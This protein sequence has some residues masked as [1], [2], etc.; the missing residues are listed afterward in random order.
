MPAKSSVMPCRPRMG[1][2]ARSD[3][4]F[5][6]GAPRS[7]GAWSAPARSTAESGSAR[8]GPRWRRRRLAGPPSPLPDRRS[9]P[10]CGAVP[11]RAVTQARA[12][13]LDGRVGDKVYAPSRPGSPA[14]A[15]T[16][17][18]KPS[19]SGQGS[20]PSEMLI[21]AERRPEPGGPRFGL[22]RRHVTDTETIDALVVPHQ[23]GDIKR[24]EKP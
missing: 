9:S 23:R 24:S 5:R 15:E 20:P 19:A 12:C 6:I 2:P 10:F 3:R 21:S 7:T 18:C 14:P 1:P 22:G 16:Q 11:G 4:R 17:E 13:F 8:S